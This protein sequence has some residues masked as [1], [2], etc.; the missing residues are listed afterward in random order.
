MRWAAETT[1]Q[2]PNETMDAPVP[3]HPDPRMRFNR[4]SRAWLRSSRP[5]DR[6]AYINRILPAA[7][8]REA[9]QLNLAPGDRVLDFGCA[10]AH[11]RSIFAP[12]IRYV[13]A[14]I[15]GNA[16]A[17]VEVNEAGRLPLED[18]SFDG[19]LS[20]QVLEHVANPSR[21]LDECFRMLRPRGRLLLSTH[22]I[23]VLHP[24]PIDYWR[25][26]S[27]GLRHQIHESGLR[28][29]SFEGVMGLSA[30]GIQLFQDA[31]WGHLP[32]LL[33]TPYALFLQTLIA[34]CDRLQSDRSRR[35]NA[36]VYLVV[37]EKPSP[38]E[39]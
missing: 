33:R 26:T 25:W 17:D 32:R 21:Y 36:L 28:V 19:I 37:A 34:I 30:T 8:E 39:R 4:D 1:I 27:D 22:G 18:E 2:R 12:G 31:T 35:Y 13:G 29:V 9:T 6:L 15:A 11:Y 24:D 3:E 14:D 7:I 10:D 23:M 20:T 38:S 16:A 5:W